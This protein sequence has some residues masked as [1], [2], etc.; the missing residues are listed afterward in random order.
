MKLKY[1]TVIYLFH[2]LRGLFVRYRCVAC[3][4]SSQ[5]HDVKQQGFISKI[6]CIIISK[7]HKQKQVI[8]GRRFGFVSCLCFTFSLNIFSSV[9]VFISVGR[10]FQKCIPFTEKDDKREV[11]KDVITEQ[12][13][14]IHYFQCLFVQWCKLHAWQLSCLKGVYCLIL[15]QFR[16]VTVTDWFKIW[17]S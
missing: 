10:A 1:M 3:W 7:V 2:L 17:Q 5:G 4:V 11:V 8:S 12:L 14:L 15:K 16:F 13:V 6:K 9:C